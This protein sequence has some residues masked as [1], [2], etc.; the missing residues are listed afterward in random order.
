[1][2]ALTSHHSAIGIIVVFPPRAEL[3]FLAG[4]PYWTAHSKSM[5]FRVPNEFLDILQV[6]VPDMGQ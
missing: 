1:M 2:V 3:A 4:L 5:S 6:L